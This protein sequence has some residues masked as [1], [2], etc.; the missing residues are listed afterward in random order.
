MWLRGPLLPILSAMYIGLAA[1]GCERAPTPD[2]DA[3]AVGSDHAPP[4][5]SGPDAATAPVRDTALE[6]TLRETAASLDGS[7]G[8]AV[9]HLQEDVHAS[10]NGDR[11]FALASVYKL[12]IAYAALWRGTLAPEDS[13]EVAPE[14]RAPGQTPLAA[15]AAV[16]VRLLVERSIAHSD[17]TASDVLLRSAGGPEAVAGRVAALGIRDVR[18]DRTMRQVFDDWQGRPDEGD[19]RDTGT[20]NA[21]AAL[22]ASI[23]RGDELEPKGRDLLIEA[24]RAADT[25]PNR[26][27]GG[28]PAG[29]DVGH[30]TGTL[31]PLSHDAG[32]VRLPGDCGN[33]AIA[34]FVESDGPLAER[35][36]VIAAMARAVWERFVAGCG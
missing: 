5:E 28:V 21:V 19:L 15:G 17:N 9:V 35:E 36:R 14:D 33:V 30:K 22:L 8:V 4:G 11:P 13:L 10:V 31:G 1:A 20:A 23:H 34:V 18:V 32:I 2:A 7:V 29:T 3:P 12:P 16:P 26:I 24:L 27:R 25:G 6:A